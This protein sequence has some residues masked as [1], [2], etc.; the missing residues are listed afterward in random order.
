VDAAIASADGSLIPLPQQYPYTDST[1]EERERNITRLYMGTLISILGLA[2]FI[3]FV[4]ICYQLTGQMATEREIGM[5]QLIEAMMPNQRRWQP[6][7]ARLL[8]SHLAFDILYLPGWVISGAI[9]TRL[10]YPSSQTGI[11]I[12]YF[13]LAGLALSSWSIAFASLFRKAQLS[14]ITVTIV[15]I[16]L[17]IIV[18]VQTPETTGA[19]VILALLFPPMNFTL[20]IIYMAYWQR[21]NLAAVL[22]EAPPGS[23]WRVSG[24]VFFVLCVIQILVYPLVGAF[25][26]RAL[27]GTAS[28]AR[29]MHHSADS[30]TARITNLT[31]QYSPSWLYRTVWSR[32]SKNKRETVSAVNDISFTIRAGEIHVLLGANGSGKSTTM[33]MLAGLQS[34]TS[35]TIDINGIGGVG[36]CPQKNVLWDKLTCEEHVYYFNQLKAQGQKGKSADHRDLLTKCDLAHKISARSESL[37]GGQMRKLQLAMM[38]TGG[39]NLCLIDEVSSGIDPLSR[40]KV[41]DILLAERGH[42]AMLFTTH[43]LDEGDL[44]S[45]HITILSKG[46]LAANGTA[47]ALKHQLGGGYRVKIYTENWD[48]FKEPEDWSSIPRRNHA[49]H[50]VYN[51]PDS[52]AAAVFVTRL[53]HLGVTDYR[54]SGPSIE[55]VFLKL[56]SEFNN[57]HTLHD[58]AT[59]LTNVSSLQ[60]EKGLEL[61]KGKRIS[62]GAQT[63]VLFRKRIT[64]LRRNYLPY[65]A[66]VLIPI[67]AA[68]LVTLFL[69]GFSPLSC[70]PDASSSTEKVV[71]FATL[72][73]DPFDFPAGPTAQIPTTLLSDLYPG[74]V[75]AIAPIGSVDAL[76]DYVQSN[77]SRVFPG[78]YYLDAQGGAPLFAWRGNYELD[79]AILTQNILDS[80]LLGSPI[81]TTY[82]AFQRPW[83]PSAG[84]TLQFIL[85]F[86]LAMCAYPGF[87]A[88]YP[89]RERVAKVR[90]LHYSNGIR[91]FPLWLA[92]TI[93]D[94]MFV[95]IVSIVAIVIFVGVSSALYAPGTLFVVFFL[96]GLAALLCSYVISLFVT[97]Q[98]ASFAFAAGMQC[99]WFLIYFI[100]FMAIIT[101]APTEDIDSYGK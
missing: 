31:K 75:D 10:N 1:P 28:K 94:F 19:I 30:E 65:M 91:A 40:R 92:Y 39:S 69:K 47:V 34:P 87:F 7:A 52:G 101:F 74:L 61:A 79:Y 24:T 68:G 50:V 63:W 98:L 8:S 35:G 72:D 60:S 36:I 32:F 22:S 44:L 100:A 85:Y 16:V 15:S 33:D 54:V 58:D 51:L 42:R 4:G 6:Q 43:F 17:A 66:A 46:T 73:S 49:D 84:K 71:S 70:S 80:S 78:G 57:D 9:V 41:W 56:S 97:S 12:G 59:S 99:C 5:S 18:Q 88:L 13:I 83:A 90:A 55:D 11:L 3:G 89:T 95:L 14:G 29:N 23:P 82:Q 96:Y 45:D 21:S 86:G 62:L 77:Y 2:Y 81:V 25:I 64:I 20:F 38:L 67:I 93:F 37:S 53:E 27:Y 26:E 76:I 48:E